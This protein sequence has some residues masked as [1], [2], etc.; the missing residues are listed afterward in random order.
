[1][2][3]RALRIQLVKVRTETCFFMRRELTIAKEGLSCCVTHCNGLVGAP[4]KRDIALEHEEA[5]SLE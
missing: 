2:F 4:W 1:M 5:L 3:Q